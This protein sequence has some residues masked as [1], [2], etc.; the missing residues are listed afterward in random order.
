MSV[1]THLLVSHV[2]L[3]SEQAMIRDAPAREQLPNRQ[4]ACRSVHVQ[5][6]EGTCA[7]AGEYQQIT[8]AMVW[9]AFHLIVNT[10][11]VERDVVGAKSNTKRL[12]AAL[13]C[14]FG[15]AARREIDTNDLRVRADM[16]LPVRQSKR[17]GPCLGP[18]STITIS[19]HR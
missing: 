12:V 19:G 17:G 3:M 15:E 8:V 5:S 10:T 2:S 16:R 14:V 18:P 13:Q 4:R 1:R 11:D 7:R 9:N 6:H